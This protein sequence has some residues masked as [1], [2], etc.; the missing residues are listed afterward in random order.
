[1][2]ILLTTLILLIYLIIGILIVN[3]ICTTILKHEPIVKDEE[4]L[5]GAFVV[6][7]PSLFFI[8]IIYFIGKFTRN[9]IY[10]FRRKKKC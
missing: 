3:L 1:M 5:L 8:L 6:L 10:K 9:I 2:K 7:W 4:I